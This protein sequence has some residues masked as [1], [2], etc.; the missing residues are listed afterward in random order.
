[1]KD[2][3][4]ISTFQYDIKWNDKISNI[5][6]IE[7]AFGTLPETDFVILPELFDTG[8]VTDVNILN[9]TENNYTKS[10]LIET[11]AKF[12]FAIGGSSIYNENGKYFNRFFVA[13]PDNS[14]DFYDKKHL[15][16]IAGEDKYISTG[17]FQKIINIDNWRVKL[18]V[19][20]DLRFPVW[21]RN[22]NDYDIL[23]YVAN[24]PIG[25]I[26][27]WKALLIARAIENQAYTI[28]VNRIGTDAHG[29]NYPGKSLVVSPKGEVL[30]EAKENQQHI[31]TIT[32]DYNYLQKLRQKFPVLKD[33]DRFTI[34]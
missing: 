6:L 2:F 3:I 9:E 26:E 7:D 34:L 13:K 21:A 22:N 12:N 11:A 27:Q 17:N 16:A 14:L 19:C 24:W 25:R 32:L 1:M 5:N 23:V 8:F 30:Y 33:A 18:L 15:F 28:G 4:K 31:N 29:F 10:W 20:Y